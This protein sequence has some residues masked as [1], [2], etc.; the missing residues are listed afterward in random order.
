MKRKVMTM[1][2]SRRL[3]KTYTLKHRQVTRNTEGGD[4][5]SWAD[6]VEIRAT[7]WQASGKIFVEMYGERLAYMR[8]M[9]YEGE[10]VIN[11]NDGICVFV[12]ADTQP[13]YRVVSVNADHK[14][15]LYLLEAIR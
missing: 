8:N 7:I 9:E 6:P 11:E 3:Q 12:S 15:V 4:V 13:D 5:E 10:E 2:M 1:R 14:P